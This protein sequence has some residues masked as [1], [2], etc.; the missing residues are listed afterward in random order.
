VLHISLACN[1]FLDHPQNFQVCWRGS[2]PSC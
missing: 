2:H 1:V